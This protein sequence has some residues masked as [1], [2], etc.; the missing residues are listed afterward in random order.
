MVK[1]INHTPFVRQACPASKSLTGAEV[2][3][4]DAATGHPGKLALLKQAIEAGTDASVLDPVT[5]PL[6][7]FVPS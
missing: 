2:L 3:P 5:L 1:T 7:D 4:D 6:Q